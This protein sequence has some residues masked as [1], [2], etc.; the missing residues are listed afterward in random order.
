M[1]LQNIYNDR[2]TIYLFTRSEKGELKISKDNSFYP[3]FYEL[4]EQGT[5]NT[6]DNRKVK[7]IICNEPKEVSKRRTSDSYEADVLFTKRYIIDKV[8]RIEKS[9]TRFC[10]FDS[11]ILTKELPDTNK[12]EFPV[13]CITTYDSYTKE[14][15]TWF[16]MEWENEY[17]MLEDFCDYIKTISPDLLLAWN[18]SFDYNY[19]FNRIPDLAI[20]LS[21]I[22]K[23]NYCNGGIFPA[24]I[25]L[26]D[27]L[28]WDRRITLN[29]RQV[30][31]LDNVLEEELGQGKKYKN[32]DFS[33]LH[34]DIKLRNQEDVVGM[35]KLEEKNNYIGYFDEIRLFST[36][37]WD[38][39]VANSKILDMV[40]L[41]EAKKRNL[42]LPSKK[43]KKEAK[44]YEGAYRRAE[45]GV[46]H[47]LYKADVASMY[48][49]QLINFCLDTQNILDLKDVDSITPEYLEENNIV[50]IPL[51]SP[52]YVKQ[53]SNAML[54]DLSRFLI[55]QKDLIKK[56]LKNA[57][58]EYGD[59]DDK[60]KLVQSKYDA[61][62]ALTN[63]LYGVM[64]YPSFRLYSLDIASAI[65][66]LAR[67]LLKYAEEKMISFN[68]PVYYTDTDAL[69][70]FSNT[71]EIELLNK[72]VVDWGIE[73]FNKHDINIRFESEG[74]LKSILILG[75][76]HYYAIKENSNKPEVKGIEMKRSS[77][78]EYE[79][80]FQ[81]NLI[82]KVLD[83]QGKNK[84]L[85]WIKIETERIKT[86]P[87]KEVAFP[88]KIRVEEYTE[89]TPIFLTAYENSKYLFKDFNINKGELFY[90]IFVK[91]MKR[92]L[93]G[94]IINVIAIDDKHN[95]SK[96]SKYINW[97]E[98]IRRNIISKAS[99][100]FK[101]LDWGEIEFLLSG[102]TSLF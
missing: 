51:D 47:N 91:N 52:I 36:C 57:K 77:S 38:D 18:I 99:N 93:K 70:Y 16:L 8:D 81:E 97:E 19:L 30:Y 55:S 29:R 53:D 25:T 62:K 82:K 39:L 56:E 13:S 31:K 37:L 12:A 9:L 27:Y 94:E 45:T 61:I 42:I 6:Y 72:L 24:G 101:V 35:V 90:Y 59:K 22:S 84:L 79:S 21:P 28:E 63:S 14:Y 41:R 83:N 20:K 23:S 76:C 85:N 46:F 102:Q 68:F 49:T 69:M 1:R 15:K 96:I 17:S 64:A 65:T 3:Y 67:S 48:P 5:F 2:K 66:F 92:N 40:V 78:S 75:K 44:E 33:T 11:E 89:N 98:V 71:D 58:K 54:P 80:Y 74:L 26:I 43:Q 88:C 86:L 4:D 95:F 7:K 34:Q 73:N 60:T 100:I 10:F 87:L 32:V 50:K